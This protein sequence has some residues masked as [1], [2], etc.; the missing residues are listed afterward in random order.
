MDYLNSITVQVLIFFTI[1]KDFPLIDFFI[2]EKDDLF[3]D[4]KKYRIGYN[5][6]FIADRD[7]LIDDFY[8]VK[9]IS[10]ELFNEEIKKKFDS[11]FGKISKLDNNAVLFF[12][13]V[14]SMQND[15][16]FSFNPIYCFKRLKL[17]ESKEKKMSEFVEKYFNEYTEDNLK[18]RKNYLSLNKSIEKF[19]IKLEMPYENYESKLEV[20]NKLFSDDKIRLFELL[21]Y[22][23]KEG[24]LEIADCNFLNDS[25]NTLN[26][27][28]EFKKSPE[29]I[30]DI[31]GYWK[32]YGDLRI[33]EADGVAFYKGNKLP[34]SRSGTKEFK[35]L[36]ILMKYPGK[37]ISISKIYSYIYEDE[38]NKRGERKIITELVSQ[39]RKKININKDPRPTISLIVEG[40][41]VLLIAN[42]P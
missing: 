39:V 37:K 33:N 5:I 10:Y 38:F 13:D 19:C 29:E 17:I 4:L 14:L 34:F 35:L 24:F 18:S 31:I 23:H 32:S 11:F 40:E 6:Q 28:I 15:F 22:L 1:K 20:N 9:S 8:R 36:K 25:S 26:I 30:Q 12:E 27:N 21:L 41:N 42:P 3:E 16:F 2:G 7:S